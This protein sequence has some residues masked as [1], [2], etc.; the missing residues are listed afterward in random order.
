MTTE[1]PDGESTDHLP[2]I[3]DPDVLNRLERL[4]TERF[5]ALD[6]GVIGFDENEHVTVYNTHESETA[7]LDPERVLGRALF[8]EVAPCTNNFLVAE[9]F[10]EEEHLDAWLDYVFTLRMKPTPV[11]IR[12]LASPSASRRYMLVERR[13]P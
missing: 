7:G 11:R 13:E 3:D 2:A 5:D 10:R 12:L 9:R 6:F 4:S 1:H 8:T